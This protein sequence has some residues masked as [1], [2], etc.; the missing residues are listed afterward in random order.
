VSRDDDLKRDADLI[1]QMQ[2]HGV[3]VVSVR[4]FLE[5]LAE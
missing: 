5:R 2:N 1:Y 4:R 3:E